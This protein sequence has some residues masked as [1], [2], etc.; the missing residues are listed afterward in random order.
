MADVSAGVTEGLS[1][2]IPDA[3]WLIGKD[4]APTMAGAAI[5]NAATQWTGHSKRCGVGQPRH[6]PDSKHEDSGLRRGEGGPDT[7]KRTH[8]SLKDKKNGSE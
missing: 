4:L 2:F 7:A 5:A 8:T 6:A 1:E 3:S